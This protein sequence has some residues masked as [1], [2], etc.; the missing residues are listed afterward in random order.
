M[1][2][3]PMLA[4]ITAVAPVTVVEPRCEGRRDPLG[5]DAPR[6]ALSWQ[7]RADGRRDV[8]QTAYEI[9]AAGR[10]DALAKPDLWASGRVVSRQS[11]ALPW[12][13]RPL[14][15]RQT[16]YWQVRV[17]TDSA[18][19]TAWSPPARFEMGLL[20]PGDWQGKWLNDGRATPK[21]EAAQYGDD[22][23]PLFR[24][25]FA[26][27]QGV[28]RARLYITGLGYYEASL[29]GARVGDRLL[30]PGWTTPTQRV[31]YSTYDV[32]AAL[33]Q[34]RNC[35]GVTL[36]NG[37]YNP[38]PLRL[39]GHLNL[40]DHLAHGRPRL[41]AQ[42]E[43]THAD[44][45]RQIVASDLDWKVGDGPILRNNVYLGEVY[46]AR[47]EQV[48]WDQPGFADAVWRTPAVA[49]EP[50]GAL[51]AE[52]Q[53]PIRATAIMVPRAVTEPRPGVYLF[54]LGRNFG[55]LVTLRTNAPAGTRLTLRYGELVRPDGTLN[56]MTS[57]AGQIKGVRQGTNESVGGPGAPPVAE[58]TD[59][60]IARGGEQTY[61]PR[62]TFRAF[63]YL[64]VSGLPAK[65]PLDA[66]VGHR[67]CADVP[68]VGSFECSEPLLNEIQTM[69][70]WT[71]LSNL[72]SVQSDCPH[73]E[74]FGYGGDLVATSDAFM[75][76]YDMSGFYAKAARDWADAA[77]P[78]GMLTDTAPFVGIQYCGVPWA[79]AHPLLLRQLYQYYGD[80]ALVEEQYGVA[81]R[82]LELVAK[83]YP[84]HIVTD[85]LSDHES[86]AGSP[87]PELVTPHYA[88]SARILAELAEILGKQDDAARYRRLHADIAAAYRAKFID[89]TG[90]VAPGT[91]A[92]QAV[93]L[94]TGMV[95]DA[96]RAQTL[97]RL[98]ETVG[99]ANN[100]LTTGILGTKYMLDE[101]SRGGRADLAAT[102]VRQT[103]FPGWGNMLSKGATTL[104]EHWAGSDN[105][106]S[107]NHPMFGSVSGWFQHWLGGI[108]VAPDA[109]AADR[110]WI[111]PQPVP[112]LAWVRC[113]WDSPFGPVISSWRN[114]GGRFTLD[115]D[116]PPGATATVTVPSDDARM[117]TESGRPF[118][119]GTLVG[120]GHY[121]FTAPLAASRRPPPL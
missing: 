102:V 85:G 21:D 87:A 57:V 80:R 29:N 89:A 99:T 5:I 13:G 6:P 17:W 111:R 49:T 34:G 81:R 72:F 109:V 79:M 46:D 42:L 88:L 69:C 51:R 101:L 37:W 119:A 35:L 86:L 30:D 82:W 31:L 55:G 43:I 24:R 105:T 114:E 67:L 62:F 63:R 100:H 73:R 104:W 39:W 10:A 106:F 47:R 12:A 25:E 38:L 116:I 83:K 58:Q 115:L 65:P 33:R 118:D 110:L 19:P 112:G 16:V 3:L 93:A 103:D 44:G 53:P 4:A 56:P 8:R 64:E 15:S 91:Q 84:G 108:Q 90:K 59:T 48:G 77:R 97:A 18:Q 22:P 52:A 45:S 121:T 28:E 54:D 32:A 76:N 11:V 94:W 23:A 61:T 117:V 27:R 26:L 36:G 75:A 95:P 78:D 41:L 98:T 71:F 92:A 9:R 70:D 14:G 113:R 20:Q 2:I 40:R 74:R 1:L 96:L 120:S 7:L 66:V 60:Y 50:V 107:N 68:R